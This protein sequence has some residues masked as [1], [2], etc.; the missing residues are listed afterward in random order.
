MSRTK[1]GMIGYDHI[2][3]EFRSRALKE[4]AEEVEIVAIADSDEARGANAQQKFGG[5]LYRDYRGLLEQQDVELVFVHSGNNEHKAMVLDTV[6]AGKALFCEKPLATNAADALEM[7]LAVEAAGLRNT[8]GFCSRYIPEA[9]RAKQI[10]A[11]GLL[12]KII[13]VQAVIGLAGIEEIGCPAYMASWMED[14]ARGGGGALIDEGSHAFDLLHWLVGD[15]EGVCSAI[16]NIAK[17]ALN[18]EDNA[19]TLVRFESGALGSLSTLWSLSIDIGMRSTLQL[20]GTSGTLFVDLTTK[21]PGLSLYSEQAQDESLRGW[22]S[23]HIKPSDTEPHDYLSWPTHVQ[24]YKREITDIVKRYRSGE[25][26][27][28]TFRDGLKV[29]RVT[30]AAYRSARENRFVSIDK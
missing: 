7:T 23:P 14:P 5:G 9:E 20:F 12:G 10:I 16:R 2:H 26:F 13:S 25:P 30:E 15:V 28:T 22:T 29:A 17:P 1:I 4:M 19:M 6:R 3:A 21:T 24:H 11:E 27:R 18:V 8:V